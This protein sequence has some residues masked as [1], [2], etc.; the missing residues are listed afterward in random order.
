MVVEL[1]KRPAGF[2]WDITFKDGNDVLLQLAHLDF[3]DFPLNEGT[4]LYISK[5]ILT[6]DRSGC[7]VMLPRGY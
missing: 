2:A 6:E 5:S 1:T 3:I 7:V 4:K